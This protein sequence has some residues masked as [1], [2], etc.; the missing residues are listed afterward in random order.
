MVDVSDRR[1]KAELKSITRPSVIG[2]IHEHGSVVGRIFN[3]IVRSN[4]LHS[5][6]QELKPAR[7]DVAVH[8]NHLVPERS[9]DTSQGDLRTNAVAIRASVSNHRDFPSTNSLEKSRKP[10]GKFGV[11]FLHDPMT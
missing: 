7:N 2:T 3:R 11:E 8:A 4:E 5:R 1:R 9:K 6:N 10:G